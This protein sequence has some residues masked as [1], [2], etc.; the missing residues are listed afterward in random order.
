M[1]LLR[2]GEAAKRLGVTTK[3][4]RRWIETGIIKAHRIRK[5]YRI[6]ETEVMRVLKE[7]KLEKAVIYTRVSSQEDKKELEEEIKHLKEYCE[8]FGLQI[9]DI[10]TDVSSA[11]DENREGL[12]KLFD[13]VEKSEI[14][15]VIITS[16]E[17]LARFGFEYLERYFNSHGVVIEI[18]PIFG[19]DDKSKKELVR[20]FL[21][22]ADLVG[23]A[24]Y[25]KY[26]G[27]KREF[28]ET[29]KNAFK[30]GKSL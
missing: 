30:E 19:K 2:T 26:S 17:K 28:I 1:E 18:V 11:M 15:R 6:P 8:R 20:D 3:T 9:V 27:R 12:K 7:K 13:L 25:G 5:E 29:I 23:D 22:F 4:L 16:K 24:L 21:T 10:I 14:S